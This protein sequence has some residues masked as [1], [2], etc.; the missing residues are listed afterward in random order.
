MLENRILS[1]YQSEFRRLNVKPQRGGVALQHCAWMVD[2]S[3]AFF[4]GDIA[5]INRWIGFIQGVLWKEGIYTI[6]QLRQHVIDAKGVAD[7]AV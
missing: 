6:D 1:F 3:L 2:E 7:A 4:G 5:K